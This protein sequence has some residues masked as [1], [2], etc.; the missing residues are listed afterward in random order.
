M[1][2]QLPLNAILAVDFERGCLKYERLC[3]QDAS[4]FFNYYVVMDLVWLDGKPFLH[5]VG[6]HTS[7]QNAIPMNRKRADGI[8]CSIVQGCAS[9]YIGYLDSMRLYK[10]SS[11]KLDSF[12]T[13]SEAHSNEIKLSGK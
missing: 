11:F 9:K 1:I 5:I 8:W 6:T 2:W 7:F 12:Q 4:Y 3:P 10:E 13:Y